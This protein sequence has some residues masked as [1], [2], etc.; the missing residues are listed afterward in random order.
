MLVLVCVLCSRRVLLVQ[1]LVKKSYGDKKKR[2]RLRNWRLQQIDREMEATNEEE[3]AADYTEFL[4]DL[5]EDKDYRR[6]VNIYHGNT[7]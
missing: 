5:E 2:H 1:I 6:N 4:E 3:Y 7:A